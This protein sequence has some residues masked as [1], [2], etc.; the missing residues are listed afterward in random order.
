MFLSLKQNIRQL[1]DGLCYLAI[2]LVSLIPSNTIRIFF[3]KNLCG[4]EIAPMVRIYTGTRV[5]GIR[6]ISIGRQTLVGEDCRLDGR[7]G[8]KN[9]CQS[10]SK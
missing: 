6:G 1:F 8:L 3:L 2:R 9:W 5:R 7:M 4:A 10:K